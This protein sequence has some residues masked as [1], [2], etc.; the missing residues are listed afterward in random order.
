[1][2]VIKTAKCNKPNFYKHAF[3]HC[4]K[5]FFKN[6]EKASRKRLPFSKKYSNINRRFTEL[7]RLCAEMSEWFKEHDWKS[8][9]GGSSPQV[10]ILFSAPYKKEVVLPLLFFLFTQQVYL[11]ENAVKTDCFPNRWKLRTAP[12]SCA[13]RV[14]LRRD[15]CI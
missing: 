14:S 12:P 9:V 10:Q 13:C 5:D 6:F 8:C 15:R 7:E 11:E 4:K 3:K 2:I 1:M